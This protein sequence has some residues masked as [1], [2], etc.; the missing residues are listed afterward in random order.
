MRKH[1]LYNSFRL[2]LID[3]YI[4]KMSPT[5][6]THINIILSHRGVDLH[7]LNK[8]DTLNIK[9]RGKTNL[10]MSLYEF[11]SF[12]RDNMNRLKSLQKS[13]ISNRG[14][15]NF[16]D[17]IKRA[18]FLRLLFDKR[19]LFRALESSRAGKKAIYK[20]LEISMEQAKDFL[21][22]GN[23]PVVAYM[24]KMEADEDAARIYQF[25]LEATSGGML[26]QRTAGVTVLLLQMLT[27]EDCVRALCDVAD[28]FR[29]I[30]VT[31]GGHPKLSYHSVSAHDAA[32]LA[33]LQEEEDINRDG[34]KGITNGL[35]NSNHEDIDTGHSQHR[36]EVLFPLSNHDWTRVD[37]D[38]LSTSR[39]PSTHLAAKT[40][41]RRRHSIATV[42][43][44]HRRKHYDLDSTVEEATKV[45]KML[46]AASARRPSSPRPSTAGGIR[47]SHRPPTIR[48]I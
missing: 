27:A 1:L 28:D 38:E 23:D 40:V 44:T 43:L 20:S 7:N 16:N 19:R 30:Y 29:R 6:S 13:Y 42:S 33:P 31:A 8:F 37:S 26:R 10:K 15:Y 36:S 2:G 45:L 48:E 35:F 46:S 3:L 18:V 11:H 39:P 24:A 17:S 22:V 5:L 14:K 34:L 12:M 4:D 9:N 21:L 41:S 47:R 25:Q 32:P